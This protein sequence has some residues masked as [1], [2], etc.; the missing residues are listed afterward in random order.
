MEKEMV[1]MFNCALLTL[2][3]CT[4]TYTHTQ[5]YHLKMQ[6]VKISFKCMH[7]THC[8]SF[9]MVVTLERMFLKCQRSLPSHYIRDCQNKLAG[10]C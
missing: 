1:F 6:V 2:D 7:M 10:I 9:D 4:H 3:S 5:Y 8:C